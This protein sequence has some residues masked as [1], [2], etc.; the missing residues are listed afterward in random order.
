M[1]T[2]LYLFASNFYLGINSLFTSSDMLA[3][4]IFGFLPRRLGIFSFG[5][6]S[7]SSPLARLASSRS[8]IT[9]LLGRPRF[10]PVPGGFGV[11][12]PDTEGLADD[13]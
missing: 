5:C 10:F 13:V 4:S 12:R 8:L 3:Q 2:V 7:G 1:S 11:E 9:A 6:S